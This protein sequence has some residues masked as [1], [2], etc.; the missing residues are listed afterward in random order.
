MEVQD[1]PLG[2][3]DKGP[4]PLLPAGSLCDHLRTV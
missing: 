2:G 3:P 1:L 4:L